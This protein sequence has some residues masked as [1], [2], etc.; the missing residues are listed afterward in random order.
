[1]HYN[2]GLI[3]VVLLIISNGYDNDAHTKV[4]AEIWEHGYTVL[5]Q[6]SQTGFFF[7]FICA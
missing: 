2:V 7:T 5:L 1:M 4:I 6:Q 3:H